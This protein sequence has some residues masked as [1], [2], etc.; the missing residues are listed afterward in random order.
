MSWAERLPDWYD[1]LSAYLRE[2]RALPFAP[3]RHDCALFFAGAVNAM[4]GVDPAK[5]LRGTYSTIPG[6]LK[7]LKRLGYSDHI[8]MARKLFPVSHWSEGRVGDGAIVTMA[9]GPALGVVIGSHALFI[10]DRRQMVLQ[11][12]KLENVVLV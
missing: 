1:R 4:T 2:T 9:D 11:L 7:R 8:E 3:G 10:E 12:D 6:G 5:G